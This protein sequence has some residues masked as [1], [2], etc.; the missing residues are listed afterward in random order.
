MSKV[1][2]DLRYV[3]YVGGLE[4][5]ILSVEVRKADREISNEGMCRHLKTDDDDYPRPSA[6]FQGVLHARF[7]FR[8]HPLA[9]I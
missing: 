1:F 9:D 6:S 8:P 2:T 4:S 7:H 5:Y 3:G